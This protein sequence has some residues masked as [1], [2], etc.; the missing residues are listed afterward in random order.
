MKTR[1]LRIRAN[2]HKF[3]RV[4]SLKFAQIRVSDSV[5][6]MQ[7]NRNYYFYIGFEFLRGAGPT[8]ARHFL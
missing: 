4:D 3:F 7:R 1:T 6:E 5:A 8:C 2:F